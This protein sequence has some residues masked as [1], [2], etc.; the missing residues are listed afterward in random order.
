MTLVQLK[1]FVTLASTGSFVKAAGAMH[2]TQPALS[3]SIKALEDDLGQLLFDRVGKRIELTA[4]GT[5]TL[6]R[7]QFVIEDI[8]QLRSSG[9]RLNSADGGRIRLGLGSGPGILLTQPILSHVANNFPKFHVEISRGSTDALV[10][11]L[12]E[13]AVDAV[14]IDIL[15]LKPSLDLKIDQQV[16]LDGAFMCRRHHPLAGKSNVRLEEL[17]R[18][19]V[20]STP[21]SDETARILVERYGS[22]AHPQ[23]LVKLSSDEISYLIQ[24]AE[25]SDAIV[26]AIKAACPSLQVISMKPALNTQ[27]R[28]GLVTVARRT[29]P[30]F[31]SEI[32]KVL[33]IVF[34]P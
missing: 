31:L 32:R 8:E 1:H 3:R 9:Q 23:E 29:E 21:L 24:V 17:L 18:Y 6:K 2:I 25:D 30:L 26:L 27:A 28:F 22:N 20:A 34:N 4:Y 33:K 11:L 10:R 5:S 13:K 14:V 12:R 15:S 7:C 19:P 16:A